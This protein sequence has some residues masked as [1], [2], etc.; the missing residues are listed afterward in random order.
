MFSSEIHIIASSSANRPKS[1]LKL[2][3]M[4][5]LS[6]KYSDIPL[7]LQIVFSAL[8]DFS[9]QK[10][11]KTH[12]CQAG[13]LSYTITLHSRSQTSSIFYLLLN[14]HSWTDDLLVFPASK[15]LEVLIL[16]FK[17]NWQK[18]WKTINQWNN[19]NNEAAL[20]F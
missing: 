1:C 14:H 6:P 11:K 5:Y 3:S 9:D 13:I 12:N 20:C 15:I 18:S 7:G 17:H 19:N 8:C 2:L 4:I 10:W 16:P